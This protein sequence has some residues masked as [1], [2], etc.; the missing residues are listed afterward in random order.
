M[1]YSSHGCFYLTHSVQV[2]CKLSAGSGHFSALY[3]FSRVD[4]VV[5]SAGLHFGLAIG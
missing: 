2:E 4:S 5:C 1:H 3:F